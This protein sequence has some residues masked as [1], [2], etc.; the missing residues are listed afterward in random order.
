[1]DRES[2]PS[3]KIIDLQLPN[4]CPYQGSLKFTTYGQPSRSTRLDRNASLRA[5]RFGLLQVRMA[6][7]R[8]TRSQQCYIAIFICLVVKAIHLE[9]VTDYSSTA[10]IAA[11]K[12]FVSRRGVPTHI[13][14]DRGTTFQ[15]AARTLQ[16]EFTQLL[17]EPKIRETLM[18]DGVT[19][20]LIS[21]LPHILVA[22]GRQG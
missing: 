15:G 20:H 14:S 9:L 1:M 5:L 11:Y 17:T 2:T 13:H 19:W 21:Q 22:Y 12:R 6:G 8:G 16:E 3:D 10:F 18:N 7:G 4:L